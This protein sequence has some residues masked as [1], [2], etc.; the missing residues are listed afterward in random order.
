MPLTLATQAHV[1]LLP[2]IKGSSTNADIMLS[3]LNIQLVRSKEALIT[4]L[5]QFHNS[6]N[7]RTRKPEFTREEYDKKYSLSNFN[8][9]II[10]FINVMNLRFPTNERGMSNELQRRIMVKNVTDFIAKNRHFFNN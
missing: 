5:L 10:N 2:T 1:I 4:V 3:T 9:I 8:A 7:R 6:V